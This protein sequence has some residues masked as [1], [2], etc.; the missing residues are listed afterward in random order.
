MLKDHGV[1][2]IVVFALGL[3][4]GIILF[5]SNRE[6]V[7]AREQPGPVEALQRTEQVR[8]R[9]CRTWDETQFLLVED[10]KSLEIKQDREQDHGH[11]LEMWNKVWE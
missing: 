9:D 8:T 6:P 11:R 2:L 7:W 1:K 4:L 10:T 3:C 5:S